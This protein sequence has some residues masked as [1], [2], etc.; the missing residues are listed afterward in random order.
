MILKHF[1]KLNWILFPDSDSLSIKYGQN[2]IEWEWFRLFNKT[3]MTMIIQFITLF[4]KRG[5]LQHC[6]YIVDEILL[7]GLRMTSNEI[8]SIINSVKLLRDIDGN[9]EAELLLDGQ[10]ELD[11]IQRIKTQIFGEMSSTVN[12]RR[13][14]RADRATYLGSINGI[15]ILN[16]IKH[17]SSNSTLIQK[18]LVESIERGASRQKAYTWAAAKLLNWTALRTTGANLL[19]PNILL[20]L[21]FYSIIKYFILLFYS[22]IR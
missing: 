11:N 12:L 3:T 9:V 20:S 13:R 4:I 21:E 1:T 14:T 16:N 18:C 19:K 7:L 22:I 15:E 2:Y 10:H 5:Q 8:D 6:K 17:T